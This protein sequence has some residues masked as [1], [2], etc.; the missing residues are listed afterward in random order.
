M[1]RYTD[2]QDIVRVIYVQYPN[3]HKIYC[4]FSVIGVADILAHLKCKVRGLEWPC[5]LMSQSQIWRYTEWHK[6]GEKLCIYQKRHPHIEDIYITIIYLSESKHI[7]RCICCIS[8]Q[9][10]MSYVR[11]RW[12]W[13]VPG[14]DRRAV[15]QMWRDV[16][17][18]FGK[19]FQT[20]L[21]RDR[22]SVV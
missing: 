6:N 7:W 17:E 22:K 15:G 19:P 14:N 11:L 1:Y 5:K 18:P 16:F 20:E 9:H 8:D 10:V 4:D 3:M 12:A 13:W 2:I 21:C